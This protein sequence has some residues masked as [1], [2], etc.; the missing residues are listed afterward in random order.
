MDPKREIGGHLP[1][2]AH[3]PVE[4]LHAAAQRLPVDS[5]TLPLC[6]PKPVKAS[7]TKA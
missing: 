7:P 3:T 2:S 4:Q 5:P 1:L 6:G